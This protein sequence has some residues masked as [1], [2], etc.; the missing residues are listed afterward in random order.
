M[1]GSVRYLNLWKLWG[2]LFVDRILRRKNIEISKSQRVFFVDSQGSCTG[3]AIVSPPGLVEKMFKIGFGEMV[4]SCFRRWSDGNSVFALDLH[5]D[6]NVHTHNY[7]F[8]FIHNIYNILCVFI[9]SLVVCTLVAL[10]S[11]ISYT[12]MTRN[13]SSRH[14]T[15]NIYI[16]LPLFG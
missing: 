1:C 10:S 3:S 14:S 13:R 7:I 11:Y 6:T 9:C 4:L 15:Y 2:R 12:F 5:T 8:T 16:Y